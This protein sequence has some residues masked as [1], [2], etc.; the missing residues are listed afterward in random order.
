MADPARDTAICY[1][2]KGLTRNEGSC[3]FCTDRSDSVW[4]I[5]SRHPDRRLVVMVCDACAKSL[6]GDLEKDNG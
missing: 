3:N 5:R 1:A 6:V 4:V 2:R